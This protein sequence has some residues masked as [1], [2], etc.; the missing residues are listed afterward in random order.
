MCSHTSHLALEPESEQDVRHC[1]FHVE[2]NLNV[3]MLRYNARRPGRVILNPRKIEV[4]QGQH[5]P[6]TGEPQVL[7]HNPGK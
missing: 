2:V 5:C 7:P 6:G 1:E 3:G 4:G